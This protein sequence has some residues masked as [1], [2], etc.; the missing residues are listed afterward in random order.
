MSVSSAS[1]SSLS[2]LSPAPSTDDE[3][4]AAEAKR[5][6]G[7]ERYFKPASSAD[8]QPKRTPT[9]SPPP[10]P[11]SPPHEYVLADN[12]DITFIVMF[13]A[14]FS[15]CFPK[16]LPHFGPQDIERDVADIAPGEQA[17]RLLC[18]LIGLVLN[19]KKDVE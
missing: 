5:N 18:A 19:R 17:E 8:A 4:V 3:A 12:P 13:R 15:D 1:S 14:R 10:R 6:V 11:P 16:S 7:I 9:P 2:S